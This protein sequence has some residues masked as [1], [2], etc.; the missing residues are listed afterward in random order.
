MP[1]RPSHESA[2]AAAARVSCCAALFTSG[3]QPAK[4]S[5]VEVEGGQTEP[6][7]VAEPD[8]YASDPELDPS[9]RKP[10]KSEQRLA[11]EQCQAQVS[12]ALERGG[13]GPADVDCCHAIAKNAYAGMEP[14]VD[15]TTALEQRTGDDQHWWASSNACCTLIDYSESACSPWGPPTPPSRLARGSAQAAASERLDLRCLARAERPIGI[16]DARLDQGLR[17]AAIATWRARMV[18]EYGS[19]PVFE[20]LVAQLEAL[21]RLD[22][23]TI[24]PARSFADEERRHG[25][26]CGA[27]V[28]ALGGA[29]EAPALARQEFPRHPD[30]ATD[31]EACLRNLLSVCCLSETV[32]VA[33]IAAERHDMPAGPLRE[34]LTGIWAD[35]CG[36]ANFGW[37]LLPELLAEAD[38]DTRAR[39]GEYLRLAFAEL[40]A[41]ELA[42]LPASF[43][44]PPGGEAYGLCTGADAREL[45]YATLERVIVPGLEARGLPARRAWATRDRAD[46]IAESSVYPRNS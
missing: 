46:R 30:A 5:P 7:I 32:A 41:H 33:L 20:G 3:C 14:G 38:A 44:A 9:T 13:V 22:D 10:P 40:E 4:G 24:E 1:P 6:P 17:A 2:L 12:D 27:V 39:L 16:A 11:L 15:E 23:A 36:H 35:E 45:F 19:A 21:A 28:E 25:I 34:L 26:L 18:N 8:P 31:L 29:A 42:H 37:R 43:V